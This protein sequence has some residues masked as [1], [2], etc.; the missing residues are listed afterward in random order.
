[1]EIITES[2]RKF[3]TNSAIIVSSLAV[4]SEVFA[5]T[6]KPQPLNLFNTHIQKSFHPKIFTKS[7]RYDIMGLFEFDKALMDYRAYKIKRMDIK[8]V[9]LLYKIQKRIGFNR[10]INILSGYRS[11][12]TNRY[13][14]RHHHGVAKH[15]YHIKA[16][17]VDIHIDGMRLSRARDLIRSINHGGVGY[18][19][20]SS[21]IHADVGPRR[22]W[23]TLS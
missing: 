9:N 8:L 4:P 20:N 18:Y 22:N 13:L 15:S 3:L 16:E 6:R 7:G 17:A 5:R 12:E 21:F 23:T 1:M 11:P 14:R 2:R 10:R 19:P